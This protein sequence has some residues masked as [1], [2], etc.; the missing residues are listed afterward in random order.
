MP[1][2]VLLIYPPSTPNERGAGKLAGRDGDQITVPYGLLTIVAH[3]RAHGFDADVLNLSTFT[4]QEATAA[5]E[6]CPADLFGISGYTAYRATAAALGDE[7]KERY[8]ESHLTIGGPH[9]S[10]LPLEWLAHYPAFDTVVIGEGE[11]TALDLATQ[12]SAGESP[13][14]IAGTAYRDD[15]TPALAG[16]RDFIADLDTVGKPWEH[17][18]YCF[19]VTSRG[20]PGKCTYCCTPTFWGRKIR[21]RSAENVLNELEELVGRHGHRLLRIKDDT[22]TAHRKR[23]L[24]ICEGIVERGLEVRW[25]CDTRVDFA[26]PEVLAAMRRA[27]CTTVSFGVESGSAEVLSSI[28]KRT[29]VQQALDA[30]AAARDLGMDVRFY[31]MV[32]NRGESP[33]SIRETMELIGEARP[34]HFALNLFNIAPGTKE[35]E[36]AREEG[37]ITVEDYFTKPDEAFFFNRGEKS[38]AMDHI[39]TQL[40]SKLGGSEQTFAP[41]TTGDRELA[42][43]RHPDVLL[44]YTALA[45]CYCHERRFDEAERLIHRAAEQLGGETP[46]ILHYLACI[47]FAKGDVASAQEYFHRAFAA[48]PEDKNLRRNL[49]LR[50]QTGATSAQHRDALAEALLANVSPNTLLPVG[51]PALPMALG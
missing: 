44:S 10:A 12:L 48:A 32:G 47:A 37:L 19:V 7:I 45:Q 9:V 36:I 42:L 17:F 5:I 30:T 24:A 28:G 51:Q 3:L 41:Y 16:P 35:F 38:P 8:P 4:W 14:G 1:F 13:C 31:L 39:L 22:F 40:G 34:T 20:C 18:D 21:F 26:N 11:A 23:A 50:R 29:N 46:E 15:G 27:G 2:R 25:T 33:T 6:S 43:D 49:A